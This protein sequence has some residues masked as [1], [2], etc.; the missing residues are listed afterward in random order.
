MNDQA[1]SRQLVAVLMADIAGFSRLTREDE[2]RTFKLVRGALNEFSQIIE[3]HD[4]ELIGYQGDSVFAVFNSARNALLSAHQAQKYF[5]D[6]NIGLAESEKMLFRVGLNL[7]DVIQD[8]AGVFGDDVNITSRIESLAPVGGISVSGAFFDAVSS[9]T[10]LNFQ[11][12]GE[13]KVKNINSPVRIYDVIDT[14]LPKP[15]KP[16]SLSKSK[17]RGLSAGL[18]FSLPLL[19][20]VYVL[21]G[22]IDNETAHTQNFKTEEIKK[23]YPKLSYYLLEI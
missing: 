9:K 22:K 15:K 13:H 7:G 4:G 20:V 23:Y 16:T 3:Q 10:E 8:E 1:Q 21:W 17:Y 19:I 12:R 14:S 6:K 5:F 18:L 11:Y 2:D